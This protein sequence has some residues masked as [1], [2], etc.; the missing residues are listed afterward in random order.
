MKSRT[1]GGEKG[2]SLYVTPRIHIHPTT[3]FE[4]TSSFAGLP[5]SPKQLPPGGVSTPQKT[6]AS[7]L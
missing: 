7:V 2:S 5:E 1:K 6:P 3:S 4:S